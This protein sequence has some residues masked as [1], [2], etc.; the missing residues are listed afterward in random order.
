MTEQE[1][2]N[3]LWNYPERFLN[4]P[5]TQFT[6]QE[7][8]A[9]GRADLI[10]EDS[11]GRLLV[12][13]IKK[14]KLG[15]DA[16]PQLR[17][18]FG[19]MKRRH[20][21]RRVELMVVAN[22]IPEERRLS[23]EDLNIECREISEKRLRDVAAE[24]KYV[25]RSEIVP[26]QGAA[27]EVSQPEAEKTAQSMPSTIPSQQKWDE[28]QNPVAVSILGECTLLLG[29]TDPTV[30]FVPLPTGGG[31]G[32]GRLYAVIGSHGRPLNPIPEGSAQPQPVR[33]EAGPRLR[34]RAGG[35]RSRNPPYLKIS[36]LARGHK[37]GWA[38][39]LQQ[40]QIE[41]FVRNDAQRKDYLAFR[42]N[43]PE[44]AREIGSLLK[45]MFVDSRE[46]DK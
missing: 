42:V 22:S 45:R 15:R 25:F 26:M 9:V 31:S 10:F 37:D 20:P 3:L 46:R 41:L 4:E 5:L 24:T 8:S 23:C 43:S 30:E 40:A 35:S 32:G 13:E 14:G 29:E 38:K 7:S 21:E 27:P 12:I 6:R 2:E 36:V 17:D 33:L 39:E 11:L 1:M 19:M 34:Q 28:W 44:E 18:Y 16:A